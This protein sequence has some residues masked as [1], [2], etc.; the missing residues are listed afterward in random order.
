[1]NGFATRAVY[2]KNAGARHKPETEKRPEK[3][4]RAMEI[5]PALLVS[6]LKMTRAA[7]AAGANWHKWIRRKTSRNSA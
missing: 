1:M 3:L 2:G 5:E 6:W 4:A 7:P